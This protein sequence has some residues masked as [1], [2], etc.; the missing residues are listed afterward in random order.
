[1]AQRQAGQNGQAPAHSRTRAKRDTSAKRQSI[2]DAARRVFVEAGHDNAS[3]DRIALVA[4]ASK[5][6]VYNHFATKE[7]LFQAVLD[8]FGQE[9]HALK[10]L[11]YDPSRPL[12]AQLAEFADAEIALA[13]NPDW[14]DFIKVL[15]PVFLR[16]PGLARSAAERNPPAN[17]GLTAWLRAAAADG[18]L[19]VEDPAL[20]AR[21]FSAMTGGAFV[22]PAL[23][24]GGLDQAAL[25]RLK[26]ELI[27]TFLDRYR[28][29]A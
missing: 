4:G 6:T 11:P 9:A 16:S 1:M 17:D 24:Q 21:V 20:A 10:R 19:S 15:L 7:A 22:W 27:A 26:N 8:Q 5:R 25:P 23:Y 29:H 3:M 28:R 18:R 14:L 2:L 13:R 12:E